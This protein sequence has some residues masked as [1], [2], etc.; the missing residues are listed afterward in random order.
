M[1][2]GL[3]L[4][5]LEINPPPAVQEGLLQVTHIST[6]SGFYRASHRTGVSCLNP[7]LEGN[8][9]ESEAVPGFC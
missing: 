4:E 1:S 8:E 9:E 3:V 7:A 2:L 6:D 5:R